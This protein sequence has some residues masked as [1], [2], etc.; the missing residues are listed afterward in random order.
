MVPENTRQTLKIDEAFP[1]L[2]AIGGVDVAQAAT[3]RIAR[4]LLPFLFVLYIIAFLDRMK[5]SA[6][7][8]QMPG[9]LG[10]YPGL[11]VDKF[12]FR[13]PLSGSAWK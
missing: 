12:S 1:T 10:L 7:A 5:M 11:P 4:R 13:K 9:D 6:A 2:S 8:L 3:R